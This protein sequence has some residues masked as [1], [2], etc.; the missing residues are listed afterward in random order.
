MAIEDMVTVMRRIIAMKNGRKFFMLF[1]ILSVLVSGAHGQKESLLIGPGDML[2]VNVFDTPELEQHARVTDGGDLPLVMG[3]AVHVASLTPAEA[4]RAVEGALEKGGFLNHPKVAITVEEYATAKVTVL[5]EVRTPGAYPINTPRTVLD[6]LTL[7]GGLTPNADRKVI[8]ERRGTKE[9]VPYYVSN[10]A[11]AALDT[12]V[13]VNPG[14]TL[15]VPRAGIVYVLG[16]VAHPGG[17]VMA[18]N[19]SQ[20]TVLQLV[21]R[22][23]GTNTSAVPSHAKLIH[24]QAS[25]YVEEALPLS[26]MQKG[27]RADIA[28]QPD[29]IIWVPFSYLRHFATNGAAVVGQI[30][31]AAIYNF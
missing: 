8:I 14:D 28:L 9:K 10:K 3:G 13:T 20:L 29:D 5:G 18:N 7:A 25:S 22:A 27:N 21:A 11:D 23:G 4:S 1:A 26:A 30:G 31:A 16:D 19:E 2:H 24:K 12:A 6:V 17:Y 15:V